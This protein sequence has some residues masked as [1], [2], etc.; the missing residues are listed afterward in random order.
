MPRNALDDCA[1]N[2]RARILRDLARDA[3]VADHRIREREDLSG[4]RWVGQRFFVSGHA[5][6]EDRL[7]Q[8]KPFVFQ[9]VSIE[10]GTVCQ[11]E[12]CGFFHQSYEC[13]PE[14]IRPSCIT[15]FPSTIVAVA[16][17]GSVM[18]AKGVDL[19]LEWKRDGSTVHSRWAKIVTSAGDPGASEPPGTPKMRAG[20]VEN[21]STNR[22]S[23]KSGSACAYAPTAISR[24]VNPTA[25][26]E[27]STLF[28]SDVCGA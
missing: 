9:A 25:P 16:R 19:P 14:K 2:A 27:I 20:F 3:V 1:G 7:A 18:P 17:R 12:R 8:R 6:V 10:P 23:G 11:E 4:V 22:A 13:T 26:L 5:R 21:I 24:P 28:S 15:S